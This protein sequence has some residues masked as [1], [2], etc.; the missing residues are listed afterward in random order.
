MNC[1]R[2]GKFAGPQTTK[3]V[4]G[5]F[6]KTLHPLQEMYDRSLTSLQFIYGI[7]AQIAIM[8]AKGHTI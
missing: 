8:V 4:F 7:V 6:K 3:G 2:L 5:I 1:G